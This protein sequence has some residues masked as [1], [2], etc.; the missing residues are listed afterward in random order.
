MNPEIYILFL[1][2]PLGLETTIA[3]SKHPR[4]LERLY[5]AIPEEVAPS[6][7]GWANALYYIEKGNLVKMYDGHYWGGYEIRKIR[8][9]NQVDERT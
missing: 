3:W 7:W 4:D 2:R 9:S 6:S 1:I 5:Q 8:H